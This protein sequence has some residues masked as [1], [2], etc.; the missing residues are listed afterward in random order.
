MK[1]QK[2]FKT[3]PGK[4]I[5]PGDSRDLFSLDIEKIRNNFNEQGILLYS[6]FDLSDEAFVKFTAQFSDQFYKHS[7][8]SVRP[9]YGKDDTV[10]EVLIGT[11]FVELH[12]EMFYMPVRP[13]I[14][15]L[16][17]V[18]PAIRGGQT[19]VCD[20]QRFYEALPKDLKSYFNQVEI[21]YKHNWDPSGWNAFLK[22]Q[23]IQEALQKVQ[24]KKG[25]SNARVSGDRL[26]FEFQTPGV[27][28]LHG[29]KVFI[30]S[31]ANVYQYKHLKVIDVEFSDG[32][33]ISEDFIKELNQIGETVTENINWKPN[34]IVMIDN[35]RF[36]HGR[37][38]FKGQ[39][40]I[41]TRFSS[42]A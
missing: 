30:N 41:L 19:T 33:K 42:A 25:V 7:I 28:D 21:L 36:M 14:L 6:G 13:E 15:W 8:K 34:E 27:Y 24:S 26:M 40:K 23:D 10:A 38:A 18:V 37:R 11:H 16:Y 12:G 32:Q 5:L 3:S 35:K 1:V 39:R 22:T 9:N 17:C 31:L 4:L 2:L 20:G 29:K